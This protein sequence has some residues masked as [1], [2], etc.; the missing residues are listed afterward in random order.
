MLRLAQ[1]R[2]SAKWLLTTP[3]PSTGLLS[4]VSYLVS[5]EVRALNETLPALITLEGPIAPG[6]PL[7][8]IQGWV[9]AQGFR[10]LVLR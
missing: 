2:A 6:S 10:P 4:G 7:I 5:D 3:V 8:W 9:T 1:V